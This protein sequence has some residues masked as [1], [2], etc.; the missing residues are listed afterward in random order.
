MPLRPNWFRFDSFVR[1]VEGD[2]SLPESLMNNR[3][4]L[5][6]LSMGTIGSADVSLMVKLIEI[7]KDSPHR[8]IVSKGALGDK[9]ELPDNM[10]GK[11]SVP[12]TKVR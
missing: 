10:W 5:I 8:F 2:F 12:Q 1:E 3:G 6:F 7:L 11:N 4:K 9:Y